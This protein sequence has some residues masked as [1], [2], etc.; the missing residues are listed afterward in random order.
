MEWSCYKCRRELDKEL[1][2]EIHKVI[3]LSNPP[4]HADPPEYTHWYRLCPDCYA[5]GETKDDY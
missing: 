1:Y 5:E 2:H 3:P 4:S